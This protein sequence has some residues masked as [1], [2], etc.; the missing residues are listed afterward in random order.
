MR[1]YVLRAPPRRAR[2]SFTRRRYGAQARKNV[3]ARRYGIWYAKARG[4]RFTYEK[5][6]LLCRHAKRAAG[7]APATARA[8]RHAALPARAL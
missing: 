1:S 2:A 7:A 5:R 3:F 4:V 8:Q 6:R